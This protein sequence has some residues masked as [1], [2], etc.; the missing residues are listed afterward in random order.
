[1]YIFSRKA[2]HAYC[3]LLDGNLHEVLKSISSSGNK[4]ER[5]YSLLNLPIELRS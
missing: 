5:M 4:S 1:M 2:F 3:L